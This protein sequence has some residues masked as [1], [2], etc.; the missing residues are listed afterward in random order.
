MAAWC[1]TDVSDYVR[2]QNELRESES[3]FRSLSDL[4]SDWYWEHDA[5]GRFHQLAGDLSVNGI[6]LTDV[7]GRTRWEIGALNMTEADWRGPPR[8]AGGPAAVS[9]PGIAAPAARRQHAL[10]SVSGVLVL[11]ANGVLRAT[12]AWAATCRRA[13][14]GRGPDRAPGVLR[15]PDRCPIAAC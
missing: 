7:M 14:A 13:Q 10:I 9:R 3:R 12:G 6:P 4:S 1:T 8:G 2:V 15:C 11:D 5:Q